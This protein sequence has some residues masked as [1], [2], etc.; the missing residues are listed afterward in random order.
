MNVKCL[1]FDKLHEMYFIKTK[2]F[3]LIGES[4]IHVKLGGKSITS[5]K[6]NI[7]KIGK[8]LYIGVWLPFRDI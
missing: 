8:K 4:E 5:K 3:L 2:K 1:T 7:V 6:L